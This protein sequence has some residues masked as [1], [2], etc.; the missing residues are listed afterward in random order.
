ML[1][2][3]FGASHVVAA[4][5]LGLAMAT[6][7]AH[8]DTVNSTLGATYFEVLHGTGAPDFG[9]S[10]TPNVA[11]GSALGPNGLPVVNA[12]DPGISEFNP[13]THE[14]TWWSPTFNSAVLPTGTGTISLPFASNM[15]PPN[16]TGTGDGQAFETAEFRGAFSLASSEPV[17]FE[18]GS[19]DDSFI[20]VDG[21]LIGQN[22]GIHGVTNVDFTSPTLS[23]GNHSLTVF[24][25]DREQVG[26]FL[27]LELL[28]SG[29]VITPVPEPSS[30]LMLV[31]GLA[32]LGIG[33][34]R[35][36]L[37]A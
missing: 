19:D 2:P 18:L 25:A 15:Y 1:R 9:G 14:I 6:A 16:S 5:A 13:A 8:A 11:D 31:A 17:S 35:R 29:V 33:A 20:Y 26:A 7:P 36:R 4:C 30:G 21:K 24:F 23:T 22:P 34:R 12:A 32:V 3:V 37:R 10:G 27:S 28:T